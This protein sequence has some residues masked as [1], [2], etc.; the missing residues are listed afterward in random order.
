MLALAALL[1]AWFLE[2]LVAIFCQPFQNHVLSTGKLS[3]PK[4][5]GVFLFGG[6]FLRFV[7]FG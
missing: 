4:S 2:G 5:G 1:F 7:C 3:F 6:G